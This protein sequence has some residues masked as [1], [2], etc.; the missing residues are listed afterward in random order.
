MRRFSG[1]LPPKGGGG[2][3]EGERA[4]A[5]SEYE[6]Y[7]ME[8]KE[9]YYSHSRAS[10][11]SRRVAEDEEEEKKRARRRILKATKRG[12]FTGLTLKGGVNAFAVLSRLARGKT[13][14][15][16]SKAR[17]AA[18][19]AVKFSLFVAS[20]SG[21]YVTSDEVLA[22]KFG[23]EKTKRYRAF[24]SGVVASP[25]FL[26]AGAKP[27]YSL[28]S[29]LSL[30]ALVLMSRVGAKSGNERVRRIFRVANWEHADVAVVTSSAMVILGCF[31]LKPEAVRGAYGA[32]LDRHCGKT[33]RQVE[34]LREL[35]FLPEN[36]PEGKAEDMFR[37]YCERTAIALNETGSL[38]AAKKDEMLRAMQRGG[39]KLPYSRDAVYRKFFMN[40]ANPIAHFLAFVKNSWGTSFVSHV[41]IYVFPAI[42]LHREKLLKDPKLLGK[43]FAGIAR[44][45]LF[46]TVYCALAW[47]GPDVLGRLTKK[48]T[49]TTLVC[50]VPLAGAATFIEKKSRR[51]E[52][53]TYCLDKSVES[54]VISMLSWG[55]IP[56][57][58]KNKRLDVLFFAFAAGTIC[59]CYDRKRDSFRSNYLNVFDFIL[60]N[61]GHSRHKIRHVGSYEILFQPPSVVDLDALL[62]DDD[63]DDKNNNKNNSNKSEREDEESSS[64]LRKSR[65]AAH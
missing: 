54:V 3:G 56:E 25:S 52:L 17:E 36:D 44:S 4:D 42:L 34:A 29:Y 43:L 6:K 14:L 63:D 41:P 28:A 8:S 50:G 40:D 59:M 5:S 21:L 13:S 18:E 27:N 11:S 64:R 48:V 30:K 32:F 38:S 26:L 10:S 7:K 65:L 39:V 53:A 9:R 19:D 37:E 51:G 23:A 15:E 49:P 33:K 31:I 16:A 61:R 62:D 1:K 58:W 45:S 24:L 22:A 57:S 60:G 55:Y 46:L 35:C 47:Q 12:A 20:F 2:K